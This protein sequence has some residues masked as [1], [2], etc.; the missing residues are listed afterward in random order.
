MTKMIYM[1]SPIDYITS[2]IEGF[3]EYREKLS[4]QLVNRGAV[5]FNPQGAFRMNPN[6]PD[7]IPT[8]EIRAINNHA[9][10]HSDALVAII[11]DSVKTWGVPAEIERATLTCKSV[12]V[13]RV[14][15]TNPSWSQIYHEPHVTMF[16]PPSWDHALRVVE[17]TAINIS[18]SAGLGNYES[19]G[20]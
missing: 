7:V 3:A 11:P 14:G 5:L 19:G 1:A 6:H 4:E 18:E 16:C 8:A 20:F 9:L 10:S 13:I 15:N 2:P 12:T 17:E